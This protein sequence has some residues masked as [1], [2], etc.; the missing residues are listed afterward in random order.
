MLYFLMIEFILAYYVMVFYYAQNI[1]KF[2]EM[3]VANSMKL[4]N[5]KSYDKQQA[6]VQNETLFKSI[7]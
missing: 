3:T 1:C 5:N 7:L 6:I 4:H 2:A